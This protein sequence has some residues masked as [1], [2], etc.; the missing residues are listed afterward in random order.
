MNRYTVSCK[1]IQP[2]W[3]SFYFVP[4]QLILGDRPPSR[5]MK[6]NGGNPGVRCLAPGH[7]SQTCLAWESNQQPLDHLKLASLT[8]N[9]SRSLSRATQFLC[10]LV[11]SFLHLH[12]VKQVSLEQVKFYCSHAFCNLLVSDSA[13]LQ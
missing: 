12:Y 7:F 9:I 10:V 8:I 13:K 6:L 1:S 3:H 4:L 2:P 5:L 11:P